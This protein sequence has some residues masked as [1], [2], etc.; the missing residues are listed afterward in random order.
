MGVTL[1]EAQRRSC[2]KGRLVRIEWSLSHEIL[3]GFGIQKVCAV[4]P[5][6]RKEGVTLMPRDQ[7]SQWVMSIYK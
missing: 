5:Q 4:R 6:K 3:E 1:K 2:K 7:L